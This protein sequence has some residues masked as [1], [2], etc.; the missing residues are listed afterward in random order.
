[1]QLC[2][3]HTWPPE[4]RGGRR[5]S[6]SSRKRW[7]HYKH[8]HARATTEILQYEAQQ[9]KINTEKWLNEQISAIKTVLDSMKGLEE[10]AQGQALVQQMEALK[11]QLQQVEGV[12]GQVGAAMAS[13]FKTSD[14]LEG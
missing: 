10:S 8:E 1:L 7:K 2:L 5:G 14:P 12:T 13:A 6:R 3:G 9:Q 4:S 11:A